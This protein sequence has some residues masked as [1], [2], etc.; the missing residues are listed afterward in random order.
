[1]TYCIPVCV[2]RLGELV[3][4]ICLDVPAA[5]ESEACNKVRT[6]YEQQGLTAGINTWSIRE[7]VEFESLGLHALR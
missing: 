4:S 7:M 5:S 2:R 6:F 1:M 3:E